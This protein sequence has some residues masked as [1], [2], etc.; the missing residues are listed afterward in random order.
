MKPYSNWTRKTSHHRH[1]EGEQQSEKKIREKP[2]LSFQFGEQQI[3]PNS[4]I[5]FQIFSSRFFSHCYLSFFIYLNLLLF[6]GN[7]K[8]LLLFYCCNFS[9]SFSD[10]SSGRK[11]REKMNINEN[12]VNLSLRRKSRNKIE[13]KKWKIPK[14][15]WDYSWCRWWDFES[16]SLVSMAFVRCFKGFHKSYE[17]V[18][19]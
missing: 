5:I 13:M 9:I 15:E 19:T 17:K 18:E 16:L 14:N 4:E 2:I 11:K 3:N 8:S 12:P 6:Y 10:G 1:Q 7:W